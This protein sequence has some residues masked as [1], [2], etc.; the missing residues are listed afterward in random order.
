[1]FTR[2]GRVPALVAC[3]NSGV[4]WPTAQRRGRPRV[5][6]AVPG[7]GRATDPCP[8]A[9]GPTTTSDRRS[10]R[11]ATGPRCCVTSASV[12][13]AVAASPRPDDAPQNSTSTRHTCR[14]A[15]VRHRAGGP[16]PSSSVPWRRRPLSP[17]SSAYSASRSVEVRGSACVSTSSG[18]T[19]TRATSHEGF[20]HRGVLMPAPGP[21]TSSAPPCPMRTASARSCVDSASP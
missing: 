13:R 11:P 7:R 18:W 21:T 1:M 17:G 14:L 6:P 5:P 12:V 16:T 20:G 10:R 15:T 3:L 8:D 9:P 2:A 19:S 4:A